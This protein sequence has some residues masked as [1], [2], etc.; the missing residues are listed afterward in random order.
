MLKIKKTLTFFIIFFVSGCSSLPK[1]YNHSDW[2]LW[3]NDYNNELR[4]KG[5]WLSLAGLYWLE[6]GTNTLGSAPSNQHRLPKSAPK[7]VGTI[8]IDNHQIFFKSSLDKI[9]INNTPNKSG[10]L[11]VKEAT[12]V[13]FDTF[14][15]FIIEREGK[16]AVR[17]IDNNSLAAKTF[18]GSNFYS[19]DEKSVIK[20]KLIPNTKPTTINIATVYGTNRKEKSAGLVHFNYQGNKA[21]LEAV[22]YGEDSPLYL[23]FSDSTNSKTTYG[24]GRYLKFKRPDKNGNI[25]LD[26]NRCYNPPCAFTNYATCPLPPPQNRLAFA[27]EAGELNYEKVK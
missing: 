26:F 22:D 23:F 9:S 25:I 20:A 27:I 16:Y 12:P 17:L 2:Q 13:T 6:T 10:R 4:G 18:K 14:E 5:G 8:K 15:F 1:Q 7:S 11:S 21:T 19:F 24:G 3:K